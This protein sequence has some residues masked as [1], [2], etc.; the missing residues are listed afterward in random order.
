MQ[1]LNNE[2][3]ALILPIHCIAGSI[4]SAT[5]E[6]YV[7]VLTVYSTP[8]VYLQ[9]THYQPFTHAFLYVN[10]RVKDGCGNSG[11]LFIFQYKLI[12]ISYLWG[13]GGGGGGGTRIKI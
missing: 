10:R 13:G 2:W 1:Q 4:Q 8:C 12:G 5:K 6:T 7:H 9:M 11:F 3:S